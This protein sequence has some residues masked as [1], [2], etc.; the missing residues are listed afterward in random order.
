M[1][2]IE[3]SG[4]T[5]TRGLRIFMHS[6]ALHHQRFARESQWVSITG[7]RSVHI[8]SFEFEMVAQSIVPPDQG[9]VFMDTAMGGLSAAESDAVATYRYDTQDLIQQRMILEL[10]HVDKGDRLI[11][12]ELLL[13]AI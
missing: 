10:L 3:P 6:Y 12:G 5:A 8:N 11:D 7:F 1:I 13:H 9:E 4:S 2:A